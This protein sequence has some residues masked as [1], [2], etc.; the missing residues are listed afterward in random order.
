M[1][2]LISVE[3]M[4]A[5]WAVKLGSL[6][7]PMVFSSGGR[8]ESAARELGERLSAAG[9]A[10]EIRIHDRRGALVGRFVCA[11]P[12]AWLARCA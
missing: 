7:E 6:A 11:P 5:G 3:P 9:E 2:H 8:A 12:A 4:D 10:A 1:P